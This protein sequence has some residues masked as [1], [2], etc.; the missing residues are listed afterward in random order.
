MVRNLLTIF[1]F[2]MKRIIAAF[3]VCYSFLLSFLLAVR[4]C[5]R[6]LDGRHHF[7]Q[8]IGALQVARG[9]D[10]DAERRLRLQ[11]AEQPIE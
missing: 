6:R 10:G 3:R 11:S 2:F 5:V 7:F 9:A 8:S 1:C 4:M